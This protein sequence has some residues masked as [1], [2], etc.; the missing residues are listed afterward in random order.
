MDCRAC[1]HAVATPPDRD[2]LGLYYNVVEIRG[3]GVGVLVEE[4]KDDEAEGIM[5]ALTAMAAAFA[6]RP[7]SLLLELSKE[8]EDVA[9]K[10]VLKVLRRAA[11]THNFYGHCSLCP[12]PPGSAE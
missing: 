10:G 7:A 6:R 4:V 9:R 8:L 1:A 2:V 11:L 12:L 3:R 5:D